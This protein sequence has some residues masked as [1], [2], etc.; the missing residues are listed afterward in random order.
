MDS[1]KEIIGIALV[2]AIGVGFAMA[3]TL[4]GVAYTGG[5]D[6]L[7]V[8]T[9]RFFLPALIIAVILLA[10][11][12]PLLMPK[13]DGLIAAV[14][15]LITVGYTWGLLSA[16]EVLPVPLAVLVFYL[17]PIFTTFIVAA[18]GWEKL[19]RINVIAAFVA[20]AGLALALGVSG[21][22]LNLTGVALAAMSALGLAIVSAVSSRVIRAGDP[23][24]ATFYMAATA[25]VTFVL[26]TLLFGEFRL[27]TTPTGWWGLIGTNLFYAAA[28]IGFF[29]AISKIGPGK[30]TLYSNIEPLIAIGAAFV[31][32]DQ[33]LSPWQIL[34]IVTVVGALFFAA[35]ASLKGRDS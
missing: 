33:M 20:F 27:P 31:L 9:S 24:Q 11:G 10:T 6:A 35:R 7:T 3:N 21:K 13:R 8:S 4:A 1:R 19:H 23:R 29:V 32:L 30:T 17:F 26:I 2:L 18:M 25:A 14:L 34:G 28:M 16:I 12:Q 15:G 22:G 5:T